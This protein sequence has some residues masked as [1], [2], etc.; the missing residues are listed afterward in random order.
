M[1][2]SPFKI[3]GPALVSFSGGR[4][5]AYMLWRIIQA[6][7][8]VLPDDVKVTFANT[9]KEMPQTLDF[10]RNCGDRWN[11][12]IIWLERKPGESGHRWRRVDHASASRNGEPFEALIEERKFLPN[13]V[14]RF[15]TSELK[16]RVMRDYARSLGWDEWD[17]IVGLRA[18]ERHRVARATTQTRERWTTICPLADAGV[19]VR[20]VAEFWAAQNWGLELFTVGGRTPHGNCDLCFLKPLATIAGIMRD[21][22]MRTDWW[23]K[24]EAKTGGRFR[25][26]WPTYAELRDAALAQGNLS[27]GG[28]SVTDCYCTGVD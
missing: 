17:N 21:D 16:I 7:D 1:N 18:D 9:G 19:T 4:T 27:F 10:V 20:D 23:I 15:C 6:H 28:D 22:P 24:Q 14:T 12:E 5:S 11:V 2:V 26:D 3:S 13:P 8:G 25:K